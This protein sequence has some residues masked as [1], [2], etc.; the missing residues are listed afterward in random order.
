MKK[1]T[2]FKIAGVL[3]I[4]G[5]VLTYISDHLLRGEFEPGPA[6]GIVEALR[7]LPFEPLYC[8][9]LLGYA[10]LP[11]YPLGLWLL[12]RSL[13]S[14]GRVLA[15]VPSDFIRICACIIPRL[16]LFYCF[17]LTRVSGRRWQL[18]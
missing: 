10:T 3:A 18:Q 14:A 11:L 2:F 7:T 1:Q 6:V 17:I 8:G 12:Y 9:S 15:S 5:G 4:F 16:S 13:E